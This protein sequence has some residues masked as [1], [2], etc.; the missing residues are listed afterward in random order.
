MALSR[1]FLGRRPSNW[2]TL[3][4]QLTKFYAWPP[5]APFKLTMTELLWWNEQ[6]HKITAAREK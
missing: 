1:I 2:E 4:A 6:A 5:D 3:I